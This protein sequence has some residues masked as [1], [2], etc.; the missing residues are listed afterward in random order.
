M[1]NQINHQLINQGKFKYY[2]KNQLD[3]AIHNAY[4]KLK[5]NRDGFNIFRNLLVYVQQNSQ[6]INISI[7]P[8]KLWPDA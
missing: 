3:R 6:L 8:G 2:A 1:T 5:N 4:L 7:D